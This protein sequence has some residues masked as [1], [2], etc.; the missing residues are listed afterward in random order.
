MAPPASQ[1]APKR[2]L[3]NAKF[4]SYKLN[5]DDDNEEELVQQI[6]LPS[7]SGLPGRT[8]RPI[9][10]LRLGYKEAR[11]RARWNHLA[12]GPD[13]EACWVDG[14]GNVWLIDLKEVR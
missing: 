2:E 12:P 1:W 9:S 5:F 10:E 13:G 14:E 4:E 7:G 8:L 3:Q 11:N 6:K